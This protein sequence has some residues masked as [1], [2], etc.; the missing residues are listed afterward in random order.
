MAD[1]ERNS[2]SDLLRFFGEAADR[3]GSNIRKPYKKAVDSFGAYLRSRDFE[4]GA[5]D[6]SLLEGWVIEMFLNGL[7]FRTATYYIDALSRLYAVATDDGVVPAS[8]AFDL[9]RSRLKA[10]SPDG[11]PCRITDSQFRRM[12]SVVR[13]ASACSGEMATAIGIVLFSLI[14]GCLSLEKVAR[15]KS[16]DLA[17]YAPGSEAIATRH[18]TPR[19]RYLFDLQQS[20]RTPRQ[21]DRYVA[22]CVLSLL[23]L[24]GLSVK[25]SP[26]ETLRSYWAYAAI[27]CGFSGS[28]I[29]AVLRHV[30][31]GVP[32]LGISVPALLPARQ[33][34]DIQASIA[35]MFI[36]DPLGW[37]VMRLRPGVRFSDVAARLCAFG[38]E[39]SRPELFYPCHEV[40]RRVGRRLVT[41]RRPVMADIVFF[42]SRIADIC[43]IF[44]RIGDL[45]WCY[46]N[47]P[48]SERDYAT[49]ADSEFRIFQQ[50]VGQFTPDFELG[51]AGSLP[52]REGDRIEVV[53]GPMSGRAASIARIVARP[54]GHVVYR[55]L[56]GSDN[57]MRW[58]FGIDARVARAAS[59]VAAAP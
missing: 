33:I 19:R 31:A 45:A 16:S 52:L 34:A 54:S 39:I 6:T 56:F 32:V 41:C 55:L 28:E 38:P 46:T 3:V 57:G 36:S 58:D 15:I 2:L 7:T 11:W 12:L 30:P 18:A 27:R 24:R 17:D 59:S 51:P 5:V 14:N 13:S 35:A 10:L 25:G 22:D 47:G 42:R 1:N 37:H 23:R 9:V 29:M 44:A 26:S 43:P 21:L 53:G 50:A 49:V 48:R 40:V 20:A 8:V 4:S